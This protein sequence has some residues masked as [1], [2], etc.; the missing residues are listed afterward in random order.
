MRHYPSQ[1]HRIWGKA[2]GIVENSALHP[3]MFSAEAHGRLTPS[4][5]ESSAFNSVRY[6]LEYA[7][8]G[9]SRE[10]IVADADLFI[11]AKF[12]ALVVSS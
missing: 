7:E 5:V 1:F 8:Q 6:R 12:T 2:S 10:R 9:P 11:G 3:L 4:G